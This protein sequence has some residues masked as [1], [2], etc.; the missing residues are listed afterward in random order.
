M[1]E[2]P[3]RSDIRRDPNPHLT[4]GSRAHFCLGANLARMGPVAGRRTVGHVS[5]RVFS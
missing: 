4:F 5:T 3:F 1:F 2:E